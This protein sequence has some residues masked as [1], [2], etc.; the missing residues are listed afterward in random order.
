MYVHTHNMYYLYD[1][2]ERQKNINLNYII[3]FCSVQ[4]FFIRYPLL[5]SILDTWYRYDSL[6]SLLKSIH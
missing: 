3:V 6:R 5:I 2:E 4:H 1:R